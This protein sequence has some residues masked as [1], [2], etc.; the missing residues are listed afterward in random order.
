[1]SLNML[2]LLGF[3]LPQ[4][5]EWIIIGAI[6]LVMVPMFILWVWS[7]IHCIRNRYLSENNRVLGILMIALLG[8][9]GS[10]VYLALPRES[11]AQR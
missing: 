2:G 5:P 7:L 11:E 8:I 1:M 6:L 9:I 3:A 4:G 10:A